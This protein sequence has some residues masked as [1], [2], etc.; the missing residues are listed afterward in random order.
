[1]LNL[2]QVGNTV[3]FKLFHNILKGVEVSNAIALKLGKFVLE[4]F[5]FSVKVNWHILM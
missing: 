1:M 4:S 2:I 5:T 3:T